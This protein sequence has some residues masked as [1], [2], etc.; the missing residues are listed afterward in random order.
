M[1]FVLD[2]GN[3]RIKAALFDN[4]ALVQKKTYD[5]VDILIADETFYANA[6]H[7]IIC[8]VTEDHLKFLESA[9]H[10]KVLLFESTTSL[11]IKNLYKSA[12]TLGSDRLAAA[13]GAYHL[14]PAQNVLTIDAGT[15]IKYNFVNSAN[16]YIGG[17][18]SPGINMRLQAMHHFTSR[19]PEIQPDYNYEKLTGQNTSE[20]ML[21]GALMG[22]AS[23]V[24]MMIERYLITCKSLTVILTGGDAP[25][26]C[27]QVKNRI[28]AHPDLLLIGLNTILNYTI[29]K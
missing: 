13:V 27:K 29:E 26:L 25:Y 12:A 8:S 23:E 6:S 3:T 7:I 28:F 11:P 16:E 5:N 17:A 18:I 2:F 14:Y 10:A 24:D 1:N 4:E 21:T 15:C 9:H 19:L 20:S 22:A